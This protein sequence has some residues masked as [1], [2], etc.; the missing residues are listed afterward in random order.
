MKKI[1]SGLLALFTGI[2]FTIAQ[3]SSSPVPIDPDTKLITYKEVVQ[4]E[5]TKTDLFNRAIEWINK[6]YKNPADVTRVRNPETGLIE[7]IHRI[8]LNYDE[9]G[10]NRSAGIVDYQMRIELKEGRYRYTINNF[11]LKQVSRLPIEKWLDK[12]DPGYKPAYED[13]LKQVDSQVKVLVD[14]LKKGME[15]PAPVKKD[16]W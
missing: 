8:E 2:T 16:E 13:Y 1:I 11:N 6:T 4:V 12:K 14:S 10:V 5:G 7:L 3:E 15:P 9:K